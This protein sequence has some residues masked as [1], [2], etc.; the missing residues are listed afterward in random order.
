MAEWID[1]ILYPHPDV[2]QVY[3]DRPLV[4]NKVC[5]QC[6][7]TEVAR[8]QIANHLGPRITLTCQE[9]LHVIAV[10][11]P[12]TADSWPPFRAVAYD[13]PASPAERASR[14]QLD[15]GDTPAG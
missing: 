15:S 8:Y 1:R 10:E 11:R 2:D 5:P 7:S 6:A 13:W 3:A 12:S 9:C 14:T 4:P